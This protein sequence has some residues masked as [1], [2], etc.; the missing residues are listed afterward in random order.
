MRR[1]WLVLALLLSVGV[2]LGILGVLLVQRLTPRGSRFPELPPARQGVERLADHLELA[3]G[4]RERFIALQLDFIET[5]RE[6]RQSM[7]RLRGALR[8]E[9]TASRPDRRRV[10]ELLD[11][12]QQVYTRVERAFAAVIL[13]TRELLGPRRDRAYL[14]FVGRMRAEML[15]GRR[16]GRGR[17]GPGPGGLGAGGPGPGG[18][19]P[20]GGGPSD[21]SGLGPGG[22]EPPGPGGDRT[23]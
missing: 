15:E 14:R 16:P 11:Q 3:G 8:R 5:T 2:N 21:P 17:P 20:G 1:W 18:G 12:T 19:G 9:L 4:D 10:E 23:P 13:D 22:G 6:A 7:M